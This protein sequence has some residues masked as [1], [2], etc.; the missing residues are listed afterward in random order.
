MMQNKISFDEYLKTNAVIED[1]APKQDVF[2]D[3]PRKFDFTVLFLCIIAIICVEFTYYYY[4]NNYLPINDKTYI[5]YV[6][7]NVQSE[8]QSEKININTADID[9]LCKLSGIGENKALS[10][11]A[12]RTANGN[13]ESVEELKEVSGIGD[14]IFKDIKDKICV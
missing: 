4:A 5:S 12:Y 1:D 8:A 10:I 11:V 9:T 6:S 3:T 14:A 2:V 7:T 13:F